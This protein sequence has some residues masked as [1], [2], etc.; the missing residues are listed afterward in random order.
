M[1]TAPLFALACFLAVIPAGVRGQVVIPPPVP[2][3]FI[4][5]MPP[6]VVPVVPVVPPQ[7]PVL[8]P[9]FD[10]PQATGRQGGE[11]AAG[12]PA[13]S[14]VDPVA[15]DG[16]SFP[17]APL[18]LVVAALGAAAA[19]L[20]AIAR[21]RLTSGGLIRVVAPPPGEAPEQVRAAWVG[22]ELPLVGGVSQPCTAP[23]LG[24][25]SGG[26]AGICAGYVVDGQE[27]VERLVA[28]CPKAAAWW[29]E[30]AH[31]VVAQ[32]YR[33]MFPT[34]VCHRLG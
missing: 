1:R 28:Q 7:Q 30:Y 19:I 26:S 20:V 17:F 15:P 14:R 24:S 27:A 31:Q 33:L 10:Q 29:R 32:G 13:P 12:H 22:L 25:V 11:P 16:P 9:A 3:P 8:S 23:A 18:L 6:P 21:R 5:V 4:P 2:P 34:D